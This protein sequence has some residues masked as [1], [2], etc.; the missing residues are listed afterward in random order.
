MQQCYCDSDF[1]LFGVGG[2]KR[3]PKLFWRQGE[4]G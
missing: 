2:L 4:V 3:Y 1:I